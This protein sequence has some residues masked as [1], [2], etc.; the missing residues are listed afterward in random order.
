MASTISAWHLR[1]ACSVTSRLRAVMPRGSWNL[2]VV[3]AS[4]WL[5]PLMALVVYFPTSPGGV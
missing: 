5:N 2:P 1:Q 3:K 4:E